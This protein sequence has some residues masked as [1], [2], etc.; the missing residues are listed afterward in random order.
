[1]GSSSGRD[2][3]RRTRVPRHRVSAAGGFGNSF[4]LCFVFVIGLLFL[5]VIL[6]K[7]LTRFHQI[8]VSDRMVVCDCLYGDRSL[9]PSDIRSARVEREKV[10]RRGTDYLVFS[11]VLEGRIG[12]VQ[13]SEVRLKLS[14]ERL[15]AYTRMMEA[16]VDDIN[17]RIAADEA[18]D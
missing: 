6:L 18:K 2:L 8:D 13:S 15:P 4:L 17:D 1:M 3:C 7:P 16:C 10:N 5:D 9:R 12:V 14:D 11:V